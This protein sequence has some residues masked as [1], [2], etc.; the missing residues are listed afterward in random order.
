MT[1]LCV[2]AYRFLKEEGLK[3]LCCKRGIRFQFKQ[4]VESIFHLPLNWCVTSLLKWEV[5]VLFQG[6]KRFLLKISVFELNLEDVCFLSASSYRENGVEEKKI[7][8]LSLAVGPSFSCVSMELFAMWWEQLLH[9]NKPMETINFCLPA[10][11]FC[12]H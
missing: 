7:L 5:D 10:M 2:K 3:W 9:F 6:F 1:V 8:V 11:V 12:W 4:Q